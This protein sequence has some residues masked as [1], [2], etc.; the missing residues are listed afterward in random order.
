MARA[1][2]CDPLIE[3]I[4]TARLRLPDDDKANEDAGMLANHDIE[5]WCSNRKIEYVKRSGL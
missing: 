5:L 3:H 1:A 4:Q 2:R